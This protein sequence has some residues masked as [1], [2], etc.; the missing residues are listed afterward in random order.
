MKISY[1]WLKEFVKLP[2]GAQ[3]LANRLLL[4]G[5]EVSAME[6]K[7]GGFSGVI[8]GQILEIA[9]HPNADRLSLCKVTD[10]VSEQ[11]VVCGAKNIQVGQKVP[12]A[13][14]GAALPGGKTITRSVIRGTESHGMLCSPEELGLPT[15]NN[16]ILVLGEDVELGQDVSQLVANEDWV[17]DVEVTPNRPDVLSHFGLARELAAY[18][19]LPL[20]RPAMP[21][22]PGEGHPLHVSVEAPEA[23]LRY[24]GRELSGLTVR[25]S[26]S[27]MAARL[28]ATGTRPINNVVDVTNYILA[29]LGQPL[30][31]FDADLLEEGKL[32]VRYAHP[33]EKI[34]ALDG[35]EYV[36]TSDCLVIADARRPVA[37]AGVIG[38]QDTAVSA[39]TRR[40]FLESACFKPSE[41]RRT[42]KRFR[43]RTESSY[44]FERGTDAEAV[45]L[46]GARAAELILRTAGGP[47]TSLR[48]TL[49]SD[50]YPAPSRPHPIEVSWERLKNL[51][52]TPI[53][54]ERAEERI[55]RLSEQIEKTPSGWTLT[56][57]SWR[58]DLSHVQDI[59]EEIAR[60][61]G[62]EL[63]PESASPVAPALPH[64]DLNYAV[65]ETLRERM[66]ALGF[67]EA[68]NYDFVSV[69]DL[70]KCGLGSKEKLSS[71]PALE[72]PLSA[73]WQYL[74]PSLLIGL[75]KNLNHNLNRGAADV[76]L[77]ELGKVYGSTSLTTGGAA[78]VERNTLA[79]IAVGRDPMGVYW[80][81]GQ[82]H[83][84]DF[85]RMKGFLKPL[86]TGWA[87]PTWHALTSEDRFDFAHREPLLHPGLSTG[88]FVGGKLLGGLGRLHPVIA[89]AWDL[90]DREVWVFELDVE[91]LLSIPTTPMKYRPLPAFPSVERDLSVVFDEAVSWDQVRREVLGQG[92]PL[93][94]TVELVDVFSGGGIARGSRSLTMRLRFQL[95]DRTLTDEEVELTVA[96]ALKT[97]ETEL[98]GKI[99]S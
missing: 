78:V 93:L 14:V 16:G 33:E 71:L 99:R 85:Y 60:L 8:V 6:R 63:I 91:A 44:R 45:A 21:S 29:E 70:E 28:Q 43:L 57:P 41:V 74:R 3:D 83:P 35:R 72:N 55:R 36:L 5:F 4:L 61:D 15:E 23:C 47:S 89:D 73:D 54:Q 10:G 39:K 17:M 80:Q 66:T 25:P 52:E 84:L 75:L 9:K 48:V 19:R 46:A 18:F 1:N 38:G 96:K 58:G 13:R 40:V 82:S 30:H 67:L 37:L 92:R 34:L 56:P 81:S 27:W 26:P 97:L 42:S 2:I 98:K 94:K 95:P 20:E 24:V 53:S 77:F 22:L 68:Y 49:A 65:E 50:H 7:G 12:L 11:L 79:G 51:L 59:A 87:D 32:R 86:F 90:G 64:P 76:R 88:V 69:G 62:F 31:A